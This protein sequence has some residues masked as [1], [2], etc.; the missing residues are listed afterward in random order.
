MNKLEKERPGP[1][2]IVVDTSALWHE[3]KS[4]AVSP[5][6]DEFWD[7]YSSDFELTLFIPSVVRGELL[8]Q[9]TKQALTALGRANKSLD[10]VSSVTNRNYSH[11]VTEKRVTREVEKKLDSWIQSKSAAVLSVPSDKIV[12]SDVVDASIWRKPPFSPTEDKKSEKG[13]RDALILETVAEFCT[14]DFDGDPIYFLCEDNLLR[15]TARDRLSDHE[16]FEVY[17]QVEDLRSYLTLYMES[18]ESAFVQKILSRATSKFFDSNDHS[19]LYFKAEIA[20]RLEK[21]H[22]DAFENPAQSGKPQPVLG[23]LLSQASDSN[24]VVSRGIRYWV[25]RTQ[26]KQREENGAYYWTNKLTAITEF[27]RSSSGALA[28]ALS[29]ESEIER[30]LLVLTFEIEWKSN[31]STNG[32]FRNIEYVSDNLIDRDFRSPTLN[33]IR[34][35]AVTPDRA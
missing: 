30:K 8:Y 20:D 21:A 34:Y 2:K 19:T 11:R 28:L 14:V 13:F 33:D 22:S 31:V 7:L 15:D 1:I 27:V 16:G 35:Y 4:V 23:G 6:F 18:I 26:F 5:K 9:H 17:E 12:W 25:A 32:R 29:E 3:D 24:W 10:N